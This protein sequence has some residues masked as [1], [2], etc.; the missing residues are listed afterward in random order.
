MLRADAA[1]RLGVWPVLL[2]VLHRAGRRGARRALGDRD[3]LRGPFF[4]TAAQVP[5]TATDWH[6]P[7]DPARHAL[8]L[9]LFAPG[10]IRPIW[11][12]NRLGGLPALA[13]RGD[14]AAAERLLRDWAA[15][16]PPFR[17]PAWACGQECA[18]R[19][20]TLAISL[21][22]PPGA[23]MRALLDAHARRIEATR[24]YAL[25][26]D[27][28]HAVSEAA[29][30]LAC[31][32][33][34]GDA[35][36]ERRGAAALV[37]TTQRLVTPCGAFAQPSARYH[38]LLLDTLAVTVRLW[39]RHRGAEAD[40]ALRARAAAATAW[41]ARI[42]DPVTGRLPRLGPEDPSCFADLAGTGPDDA[43][44]SLARA[45]AVFGALPLA[46]DVWVSAGWRG[47]QAGRLRAILRTGVPQRFRPAHA[48]LLH[49]DLWVGATNLL[50]D[51]G[52]GSYNPP[53]DAA[54]QGVDLAAAR[55]H[56][57][58][59]F[60]DAEPMPRVTRFLFARWPRVH[61]IPDGA[62]TRDARGMTHAR[63]VTLGAHQARIEDRIAGPFRHATLRWRL[64]PG[65]WRLLGDTVESDGARIAIGADAP[66]RLRLTDG[67]ESPAYGSL[68]R[69]P[70]LEAVVAAPATR[71]TTCIDIAA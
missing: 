62:E 55:A 71:F 47:W 10:D 68:A 70:V 16:N 38:R 29:G 14:W 4:G 27:N 28:N 1:S 53:N 59:T 15:R 44:A 56:N 52:S 48:D 46:T 23:A 2:H 31:G 3:P 57:L 32:L 9:P 37:R 25:A 34:L 63:A 49:L 36:R 58:V 8:D 51:G 39:R 18:L 61:L 30:L 7:F 54:W 40:R 12:V 13:A 24:F 11:E 17:G 33:L 41:L 65:A 22:A 20:L 64:A 67:F 6:G 26:Q 43:R 21:D 45:Q 19:A 35:K 50:R 66:V 69:V 5:V 60:D 42:M